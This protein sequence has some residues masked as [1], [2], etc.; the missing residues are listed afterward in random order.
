MSAWNER[1]SVISGPVGPSGSAGPSAYEVAVYQGYVGTINDWILSLQGKSAYALAVQEGFV[2]S[3]NEWILSLQ[4][5]VSV[6]ALNALDDVAI[7]LIKDEQ[8]LVYD[9][10]TSTWKNERGVSGKTDMTGFPVDA[11]GNYLCSLTY[12]ETT[13]TV[14]ITPTAAS[15]DVFCV[16]TSYTK[17][18]AQSI[19]HS[20]VGAGHFIYYDETGTLVTSAT[21]WDWLKHAPVCYVF[22]DVTNSR[23]IPFEERHHAG[24]DVYWHRNQHAAEGT[25]ATGSGFIV[26]GYTLNTGTDAACTFSISSGRVEDEDIRI[27]TEA[28]PDAGPYTILERAGAAGDWTITRGNIVPFLRSGTN[29]QYNQNTGGAW[30]R[31]NVPNGDYTNYYIF[32]LTALPVASV[33]PALA[34]T[35][36]YVVVP[37]QAAYNTSALAAAES[38]ASIAWGSA[39]FQEMVPLYKVTLRYQSAGGGT[40]RIIGLVRVIGTFASVTAAAQTNHGALTGLTELDH[41]ASAIINTPSG[42]LVATDVQAALNELQTD[43]DTRQLSSEKNAINGYAGLD[44]AGKVAAAQL[45]S[46]VDD[47]VEA[48]NFAALPVSGETGKIYTTL[49]TGKIYR[50]SGSAYV[51]ISASPGSTDSVTEGVTNLYFTEGRV[52]AT[53]L[54]GLSTASSAVI[55]AA[56]SVLGAFGKLQAQ[57]SG[58]LDA[59]VT[60]TNKTF[61]L[62]SNTLTGT[63]AQFN[64]ACSD[65]DFAYLG[66]ANTFS[67]NQIISVTDNT[68]AALRITQLGTGNALVVEDSANPDS[69]PFVIDNSGNVSTYGNINI[70]HNASISVDGGTPGLSLDRLATL[71]SRYTRWD[72]TSNGPIQYFTKSRSGVIGTFGLVSSGDILGTL[73]FSGDDGTTF[74][75]GAEIRADVDGTPGA[76]DMPG[77]LV[78]STTADGAST[79]TER[80][81]ID[82]NGNISIAGTAALG[83]TLR[84]SKAMTGATTTYGIYNRGVVQSDSTVS[85][86]Y[87][88]TLGGTQ[89][90]SFTLAA[91]R[92]YSANQGTVGAGSI[93]TSQYGFE[94][95]SG[96]TG[97]T[98]NYGFYGN[99]PAGTGRYNFYANGT[100]PNSFAGDV[101]IHGAGKLGYGTGSGGV[102]TQ[103]TSRATGVTLN[104]TNGAITLVSAA[105][106]STWQSFTVT[107]STVAAEDTIH[108]CQKSGTD[109]N[110]AFITNVANGS[111]QI[112]FATTGGTTVEQPVFNFAVIKGATS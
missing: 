79:S 8:I 61:N 17:V 101:Q 66:Q 23:R 6:P 63:K 98:N 31:T 58:Y 27:D 54:T 85:A 95:S 39:P 33:S 14:T 81:R 111:F 77:R 53:V 16:G 96:L 21:S 109:L 82:S 78:F 97:A 12:N 49:D 94:A 1:P 55:T 2:G 68:N 69:S 74:I 102:V 110:Q 46:Y 5:V 25:K 30:Q 90:A 73:R 15:F 93:I 20:A 41:P 80:M 108:I 86:Y 83:E 57:L 100:A 13:R 35:Q 26:S 7:S 87:F 40:T 9:A 4:A 84:N 59:V 60:F 3:L 92:H 45:P 44:A 32:G 107:N 48:A 47:V 105:G 89:A 71:V 29:T 37:G 106:L 24:R 91:L 36:Q 103:A 19:V 112:T 11:I 88:S 75:K 50:W 72:N 104:K 62:G 99:V 34:A 28:L 38:V 70:G 67:V 43:I 10:D 42:N 51:E 65:G 64:T 22:Q 52:R 76:N 56:D 18:G